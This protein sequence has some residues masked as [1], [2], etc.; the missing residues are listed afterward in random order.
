MAV[1][2]RVIWTQKW[3]SLHKISDLLWA[4]V[5]KEGVVR[6]FAYPSDLFG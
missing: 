4:K 6:W 3:N 1:V 5:P 2:H